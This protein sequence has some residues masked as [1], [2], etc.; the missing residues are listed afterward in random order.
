MDVQGCR[1]AGL[2]GCLYEVVI[3]STVTR[4]MWG[5]WIAGK[6]EVAGYIQLCN[7]KL[8]AHGQQRA[9]SEP[10]TGTSSTCYSSALV[11]TLHLSTTP[12]TLPHPTNSVVG[13]AIPPRSIA[14]GRGHRWTWDMYVIAYDQPGSFS[15]P[16]SFGSFDDEREQQQQVSKRRQQACPYMFKNQVDQ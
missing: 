1:V 2:Q 3:T 7:C 14:P 12:T 16:R 4:D 10:C 11:T 5:S 9:H 13:I 6:T 8:Q 15:R